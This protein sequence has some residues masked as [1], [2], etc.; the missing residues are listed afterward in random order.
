M[1]N[2][3]KYYPN[4]GDKVNKKYINRYL[5]DDRKYVQYVPSYILRRDEKGSIIQPTPRMGNNWINPENRV[6]MMVWFLRG[7]ELSNFI[8]SY[9]GTKPKSPPQK[10]LIKKSLPLPPLPPRILPSREKIISIPP[11]IPSKN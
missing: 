11:R 6:E 10:P 2:G 9:W 5:E 1:Q 7:K 4:E 8:K 3:K